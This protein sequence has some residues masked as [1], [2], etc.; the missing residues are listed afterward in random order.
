[1][2]L[3]DYYSV[4]AAAIKAGVPYMTLH[5]RIHRGSVPAF[6]VGDRVI[7]IHKDDVEKIKPLQKKLNLPLAKGDTSHPLWRCYYAMITRCYHEGSPHYKNYGEVGVE[8]CERWRNSFEDFVADMGPRPSK[9]HSIDR[10]PNPYGDYEPS[11]CRWATSK[12]QAANQR[13]RI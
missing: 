13:G 2:K 9:R 3:S 6:R 8:V 12:Q 4:K 5:Q 7:L 10:Y 11:N 1:M